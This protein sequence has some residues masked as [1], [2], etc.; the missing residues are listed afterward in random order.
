M[1]KTLLFLMLFASVISYEAMGQCG[2]VGLIGEFNGW[3]ADYWM[4]RNP[5]SPDLFTVIL[6]VK[7]SDDLDG[8]GT[9]EMKFRANSDWGTNWGAVDFHSGIGLPNG[10]NIPVPPGS[11]LVTFNCNTGAYDFLAT[12]GNIGLIGEFTN[13]SSD[14]FLTRDMASPDNFT[15]ILT[16]KASDDLDGNGTVEV[17]FRANADWGTN[18]GSPDFPIGIGVPNGVNIPVPFGSYLVTFNCSTGAYNFQS[19]CGEIG[20]IGEFTN[21]SSDL[22]MTRD[23]ASPDNW[24]VI[25][26]LKAADDLDGNGT[27]EVKFRMNSDWGT[28]WGA[29]DFPSGI[30]LPNGVNIPVALDNT[31]MT[32]DYLVTFNCATG[33]YNFAATSGPIS[34][35]GAFNNWNG[36]IP[37][38]RDAVNPNLWKLSRSWYANSDVKF[39]ENKDWSA[40]WGNNTFPTG[41]GT[42]NG[43]NIPLTAGKYDV[44]FDYGTLNY[45]FTVNPDICGEIGLIGDFNTWGD[46]G[47]GIATDIWM[48]RDPVYPSNFTASY[49]FTSSTNL[50]FRVDGDVTYTNVY[51]GTFPAGT[52]TV[53]GPYIA[54]PGGKYDI[55]FNCKSGDFKFT[56][57]GNG[58]SAPKVFTM[59]I[60]GKL[61]E[62]DWKINQ[63][64]S[65][66][67]L[68]APTPMGLSSA[69]F[70][71]TY[72]DSLLYV[73]IDMI[74]SSLTLFR[75]ADLFIDGNK[76]GGA[77]DS[78]DL[79]IRFT[80]L[81]NVIV[82]YP[83]DPDTIYGIKLAFVPHADFMGATAELSIPWNQIHVTPVTGGQIGFDVMLGVADSATS[84]GVDYI[85]AWNGGLQDYTNTSSFGDFLFGPLSCGCISLYNNNIGDVILQNP[86]GST[87]TYVAS[88]EL[89]AAQD[90][91]FRKDTTSAVTWG[92][93]TFP[94][95]TATVG[96]PA[97]PGT[98]GRYRITF[99]C[100]TGT[101]TFADNAA[102]A[103]VAY[104]EYAATP[105]VIDGDLGEYTLS[106]GSTIV[107]E[108]VDNNTVTWGS[109]WDMNNVYFGV[110]VVDAVVV[111]VLGNPWDNDAIE[112]Y[113]N[114]NHSR[115]GAYN[116]NFDTQL[117]QDAYENSISDDSLWKKS[118]GVPITDYSAKWKTTADGYSVEL[119]L[120]W[121]NFKFL[122]GQGRSIGFSLGNDDNNGTGATRTGQSVWYGTAN[123]WSNTADLGDL[124]LKD[125]PFFFN[126]GN[127]VDYSNE[128]VLY[129]NPASGNVYLRM[130]SDIFKGNV[131]LQVSDI[132][133][134][135]VI[136]ETYNIESNNMILMDASLFRSGI[137]FVNIIGQNGERATKKLIIR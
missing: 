69:K 134:R 33:A 110:H 68:G 30:G 94:D 11:Y 56:R 98:L 43:P 79:W 93:S 73:G 58:V 87:T 50:W 37:M 91:M 66:V 72:T 8:N 75:M 61:D 122:P 64:I 23:M 53:G 18:W 127:I 27:V 49:N 52:A 2:R 19:T 13:W 65:N 41:T 123:N 126:V 44:T 40:N 136:H 76:S 117:V 24:S 42:E 111:P 103:Q 81:G 107:V 32:T 137:Y 16:V 92:A 74:D 39:R 70:G 57:L 125:G 62:P 36:D 34:M 104:S 3:A 112:Y 7:A 130:V 60:D 129:P 128:I 47:T 90:M 96:G 119:R 25:L 118:D 86:A 48:V 88:Y 135:T 5:E 120:G 85:V 17:K 95:G 113:I 116:K 121:D 114:G 21:W 54:V 22:F 4:T 45:N 6:T 132:T 20:L 35:I 131:T 109:A 10:V 9:V 67:V 12:C 102:G 84:A 14:L 133:G 80:A 115:D 29:V 28:N 63:P 89:F 26:S 46:N 97:I 38:N 82:M 1:K 71:V 51:G 83:A 77:Y 99:D 31:G 55:T 124:Q 78:T 108:G 101:Y 105:P 100:L 15:G 106:Y 59:N